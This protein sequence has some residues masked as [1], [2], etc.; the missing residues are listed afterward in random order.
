M[1]NKPNF[2]PATR[3]TIVKAKG[4]G[5]ATPQ[6]SYCAKQSSSARRC[7]AQL[8]KQTQF[9]VPS[10]EACRRE[11]TKPIW[12]D[13]A[14][15]DAGR[16]PSYKQSQFGHAA[17]ASLASARRAL[18]VDPNHGRDAHAT[19]CRSGDRRSREGQMRQTKPNLGKLGY[20]G[21]GTYESCC[22]KHAKQT[23]FRTAEPVVQTK[24]VSRPLVQT[25][26][27]LRLRPPVATG[28]DNIGDS[29]R[30]AACQG[31]GDCAKQTQSGR[32]FK[33]GVSSVKSGKPVGELWRS[34]YFEL[35]TSTFKLGRRPAVQTNPNSGGAGAI[36]PT[37]PRGPTPCLPGTAGECASRRCWP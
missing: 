23:Q 36:R 7:R 17:R 16:G 5:D 27:I 35:Y 24:P 1:P 11:Q 18:P 15:E 28:G 33:C 21:D 3:K 6:G 22:I 37:G 32:S 19:I 20:L 12:P 2:G 34:S 8:Y 26:P 30:P 31:G 13:R 29:E 4:L 14:L 9:G 25:K 10:R